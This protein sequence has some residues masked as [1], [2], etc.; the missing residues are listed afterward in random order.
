LSTRFSLGCG[1]AVCIAVAC[2]AAR[3]PSS[4]K[5][6]DTE[7]WHR[8]SQN[9]QHEFTPEHQ[10]DLEKFADMV[11]I[12]FYPDV[13]DGE[14][15]ATTASAVLGNYKSHQATVIKSSSVPKTPDHPAEHFIAGA[16]SGLGFVEVAF[17]RFKMADN[18]GCSIVFSHRIYGEN[19]DDQMTDW[20][21]SNGAETEKA[22]MEWKEMP[23]DLE[24][25]TP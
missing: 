18:T 21:K 4:F 7:Y 20:L 17:D 15:L 12:N 3:T 6:K 8:W 10:G 22:L 11:T 24:S 1:V 25:P 16:F 23:N 9:H 19:L 5:F 2:I 14:T 13:H